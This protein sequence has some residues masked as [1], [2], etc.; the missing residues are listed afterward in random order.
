M[1]RKLVEEIELWHGNDGRGYA[2]IEI[3]VIA[4]T[5]RS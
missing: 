1:F 5:G 3:M 2:T 4:N